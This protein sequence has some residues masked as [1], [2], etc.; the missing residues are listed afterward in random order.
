MMEF[1]SNLVNKTVDPEFLDMIT[2]ATSQY[3]DRIAKGE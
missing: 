2:K 3:K 1:A